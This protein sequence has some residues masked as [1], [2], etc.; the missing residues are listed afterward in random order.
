MV[1][2]LVF[3]SVPKKYVRCLNDYSQEARNPIDLFF[4]FMNEKRLQLNIWHPV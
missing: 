2:K 3:L 1:I 4:K